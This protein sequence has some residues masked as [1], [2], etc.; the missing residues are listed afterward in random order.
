MLR[1]CVTRLLSSGGTVCNRIV[2]G[3]VPF[4]S[5]YA[6]AA[7]MVYGSSAVFDRNE[8]PMMRITYLQLGTEALEK[9]SM[10]VF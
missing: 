10:V 7:R 2:S 9:I 8:L 1:C 5:G 3:R 4:G 6:D